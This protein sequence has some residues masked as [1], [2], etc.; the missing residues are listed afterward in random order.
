MRIVAL[1]LVGRYLPGL[2][3]FFHLYFWQA[4]LIAMIVSVL[5]G[6]IKLF[7]HR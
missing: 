1:L 2:F 7:V 3:E 6:W 5:Y 4:T